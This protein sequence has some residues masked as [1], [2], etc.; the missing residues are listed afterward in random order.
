MLHNMG[1]AAANL[2]VVAEHAVRQRI[3]THD[4]PEKSSVLAQ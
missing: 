1:V 4:L 3:V 2:L